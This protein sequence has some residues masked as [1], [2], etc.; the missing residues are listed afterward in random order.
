[1]A[2]DAI[3]VGSGP[4]GLS[5]AIV[6]AQAG[7][8][9]LIREAQHTVG[10]RTRSLELTLP[11]FLHDLCSAIH[12]MAAASP[13]FRSL[14]LADHGLEWIQPPLPLVHPFDDSPP[15]ILDRGVDNTAASVS[16]DAQRYRR[17]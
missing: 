8:S 5:A 13:F 2:Y 14:P 6:L 3:I 7:L 16:P 4:N 1:M 15:A 10:G 17:L 12:P 9:V 11:G